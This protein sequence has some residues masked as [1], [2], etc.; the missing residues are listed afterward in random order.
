MLARSGLEGVP[1]A[2]GICPGA[3]ETAGNQVV[4]LAAVGDR[5]HDAFQLPRLPE[6]GN[7]RTIDRKV[8]ALVGACSADVPTDTPAPALSLPSSHNST[9][10][11]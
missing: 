2:I 10:L 8:R 3:G 9:M 1:A 7:A 5:H 4:G 6:S 11:A